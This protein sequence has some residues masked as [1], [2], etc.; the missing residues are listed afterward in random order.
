[1]AE[2]FFT[3]RKKTLPGH[4]QNLRDACFADQQSDGDEVDHVFEIPLDLVAVDIDFRHDNYLAPAD[5][6]KYFPVAARVKQGFL[7]SLFVRR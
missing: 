4:Y 2:T 1:M 5:V 7:A 3:S 6:E